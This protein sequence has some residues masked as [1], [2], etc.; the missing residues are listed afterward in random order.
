MKED[1]IN[2]IYENIIF[3]YFFDL[4]ADYLYQSLKNHQKFNVLERGRMLKM[5]KS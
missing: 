5:T 3:P 1:G 4:A 2:V